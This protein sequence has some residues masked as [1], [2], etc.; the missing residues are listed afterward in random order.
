MANGKSQDDEVY[1]FMLSHEK[2]TQAD[3]N[4][5]GCARLA[6]V[7]H[8]LDKLFGIPIGRRLVHY[9]KTDGRHGKYSEYWLLYKNESATNKRVKEIY[10]VLR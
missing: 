2:I 10:P 1:Y 4:T 5:F 8:R 6:A 3:A 7:I 9:T